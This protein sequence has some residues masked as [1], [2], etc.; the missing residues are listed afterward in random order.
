MALPQQLALQ[1]QAANADAE[2]RAR[3][4]AIQADITRQFFGGKMQQEC[5]P[6]WWEAKKPGESGFNEMASPIPTKRT[7]LSGDCCFGGHHER[8]HPQA[9]SS[10]LVLHPYRSFLWT[11]DE[12][13]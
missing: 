7:T 12:Q 1:G 5:E 9:L 2:M 4:N 8:R 6:N 11:T 3:T 13:D 10:P